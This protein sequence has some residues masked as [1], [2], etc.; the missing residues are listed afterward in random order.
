MASI[1]C[2]K[3]LGIRKILWGQIQTVTSCP[4]SS[5]TGTTAQTNNP[6]RQIRSKVIHS[7]LMLLLSSRSEETGTSVECV[8][9]REGWWLLVVVVVIEGGVP[10]WEFDR[11]D[12]YDRY[13]SL[14]WSA[15]STYS[16]LRG[17]LG[18]TPV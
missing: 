13:W 4:G 11:R 1:S 5:L 9:E 3:V 16:T 12:L 14:R 15:E 8:A 6:E 17:P 7:W 2:K 10:S 18:S